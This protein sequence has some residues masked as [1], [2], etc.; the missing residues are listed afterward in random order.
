M[1]MSAHDLAGLRDFYS[2]RAGKSVWE[3]LPTFQSEVKQ[4]LQ[5]ELLKAA[6]KGFPEM[7]RCAKASGRT[8][9]ALRLCQ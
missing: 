6:L 8:C 4:K 2:T 1:Y 3:K 9:T 5:K 7:L